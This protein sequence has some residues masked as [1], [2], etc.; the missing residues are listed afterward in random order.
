M[1][2][3]LKSFLSCKFA[4]LPLQRRTPGARSVTI[5]T[6]HCAL[7]RLSIV[8]TFSE[9]NAAVGYGAQLRDN[10]NPS[11]G[12]YDPTRAKHGL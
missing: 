6:A 8:S 5:T 2:P 1:H 7:I 10:S 12:Y 11:V 9:R 3:L 4:G